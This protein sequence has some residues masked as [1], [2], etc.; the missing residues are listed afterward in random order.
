MA[1]I[2][3]ALEQQI[4]DVPQAQREPDIHHDHEPDHLRRGVEISDGE[5]GLQGRAMTPPYSRPALF[6]ARCFPCS[7]DNHSL[8]SG[9]NSLQNF[10]GK[11]GLSSAAVAT[12]SAALMLTASWKHAA[13]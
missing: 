9:E 7:A 6:A 13:N 10:V 11:P 12:I 4:L 3:A 5:A 1:E 8:Q 2:N